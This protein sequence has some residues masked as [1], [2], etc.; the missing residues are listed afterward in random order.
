M[1]KRRIVITCEH[2]DNY[3]P[4]DFKLLFTGYENELESHLGWDPGAFAVAK[5]MVKELKCPFYFQK[6]SRLLVEVNRSIDHPQLFS[7][8]VQK[9]DDS[10]KSLLLEKYY[11][12]YRNTV[13][14]KIAGLIN[15]GY[16]VVHISIHSFTPVLNGME[17]MV[18]LGLLFDDKNSEELAFNN[19]WKDL[20][21]E[22]MPDYTIMH[23]VPY[24]GADDGFTT[25]LRNKYTSNYI[26]IEI[27]ISQKFAETPQLKEIS[28]GLIN[29]LKM[30]GINLTSLPTAC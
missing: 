9:L 28:R 8:Y 1:G 23:N 2:A 6:V 20:L 12:S 21:Q 17:R 18:E 5:L 19:Q 27:E 14:D 22:E 15:E 7:K 24:H 26:G 16:E 4:K 11:H 30:M 25:Y 13:E 29:T 10:I 3:I